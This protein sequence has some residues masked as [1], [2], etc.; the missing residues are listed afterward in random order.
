MLSLLRMPAL[1]SAG[2]VTTIFSHEGVS[3]DHRPVAIGMT[4]HAAASNIHSASLNRPRIKVRR[5]YN[6]RAVRPVVGRA[7]L[8]AP[9]LLIDPRV[10]AVPTIRESVLWV[11]RCWVLQSGAAARG[12]G[13]RGA[14]ELLYGVAATACRRAS[15]P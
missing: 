2:A 6:E 13:R 14:R 15:P 8:D 4:L 10:H 7:G 11:L 1:A 3:T 5:H 9:R 12:A